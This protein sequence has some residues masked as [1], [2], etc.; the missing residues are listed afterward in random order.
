[1]TRKS[2]TRLK[3][4]FL[5][6]HKPHRPFAGQIKVA[7]NEYSNALLVPQVVDVRVQPTPT[8]P[9]RESLA[10]QMPKSPGQDDTSKW[11]EH[12]RG[13]TQTSTSIV[14]KRMCDC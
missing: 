13:K 14:R 5:S 4:F 8:C 3:H 1:M 7:Q 10:L 9:L 12:E 6:P 2:L 11:P